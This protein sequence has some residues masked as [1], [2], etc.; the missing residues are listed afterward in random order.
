MGQD[1][2]AAAAAVTAAAAARRGVVV[3][4]GAGPA[5]AHRHSLA[6]LLCVR[7]RSTLAITTRERVRCHPSDWVCRGRTESSSCERDAT[8][9]LKQWE[10]LFLT[11]H[12]LQVLVAT[13]GAAAWHRHRSV[14]VGG[15][16]LQQQQRKRLRC[17]A[18]WCADAGA[19]VVGM[20]CATGMVFCF[21]RGSMGPQ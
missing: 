7:L 11:L 15:G 14:R 13:L 4:A 17:G 2:A 5:A 8:T 19:P 12:N 21:G 1:Q 10:I 6:L 3:P 16:A 20:A 18:W 9:V